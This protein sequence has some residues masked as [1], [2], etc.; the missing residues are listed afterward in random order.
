MGVARFCMHVGPYAPANN[1]LFKYSFI[2]I[3]MVV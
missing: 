3:E 1:H 2:F